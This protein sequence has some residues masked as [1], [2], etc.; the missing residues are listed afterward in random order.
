[1]TAVTL[2]VV[3]RGCA[4]AGSVGYALRPVTTDDRDL[5]Y[6]TGVI[7]FADGDMS[8][9]TLTIDVRADDQI[10]PDERFVVALTDIRGPLRACDTMAAVTIVNDD[11]R[12]VP[13]LTSPGVY[14]C[15]LHS[16]R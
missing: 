6:R 15:E 4:L 16:S 7:S 8:E 5:T 14:P 3:S 2:T 9:Q 11:P 13:V 12:S 10:E 1:M